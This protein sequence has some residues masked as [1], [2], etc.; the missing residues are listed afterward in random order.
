[1]NKPLVELN[2]I[3]AGYNGI[4]VIKDI[5]LCI[6]EQDFTGII[7]PNGGGKTTLLKVM[8]QLLKPYSG[9]IRMAVPDLKRKTGYVPQ[10]NR[11]DQKFPI[12]VSEIINSGLI[13]EK[14]MSKTQKNEKVDQMII[15]LGLQDICHKAVGELSG[16]QLQ[17]VLLA[18]AIINEPLL[19]I[20]DEPDSYVDKHFETFFYDM[21]QKIN[22]QTAIVLVSHDIKTVMS[23]VKSVVYINKELRT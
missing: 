12:L 13:A 2:N 6:C 15:E 22:A 4:S 10:I 8:L 5:N 18:R 19:L 16:G 3:Y 7:G 11:I 17:R 1:M 9:S 20:L 14:N 23:N 21:L